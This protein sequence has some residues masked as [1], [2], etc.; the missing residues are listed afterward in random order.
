MLEYRVAPLVSSR[1]GCPLGMQLCAL[2]LCTVLLST[3]LASKILQQVMGQD[4]LFLFTWCLLFSEL[5][6]HPIWILPI[7]GHATPGRP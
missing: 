7:Q 1:G 5:T 4:L 2:C 3:H 6:W